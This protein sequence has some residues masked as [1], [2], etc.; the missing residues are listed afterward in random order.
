MWY[1][2][3]ASNPVLSLNNT[4]SPFVPVYVLLALHACL[5]KGGRHTLV[6]QLRRTWYVAA[7]CYADLLL[8][9]CGV[10]LQLAAADSVAYC[11]KLAEIQS[12]VGLATIAM[13][14]MSRLIFKVRQCMQLLL[15]LLVL[16]VGSTL[17][18]FSTCPHTHT[19]SQQHSTAAEI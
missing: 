13:M 10:Q 16:L 14:L 3:A 17:L 11:C 8:W 12:A 15:Q 4:P 6:H 19:M 7:W 5:F 9:H 2:Q 1:K 18:N